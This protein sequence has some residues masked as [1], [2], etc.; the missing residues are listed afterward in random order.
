MRRVLWLLAVAAIV[1]ASTWWLA[2]LPGDVTLHV[3]G[4][5]ITSKTPV[6][7]VAAVL[8]ALLIYALLRLL[9]GLINLPRNWRRWRSGRN[10]AAGDIATTRTLV[11]L[12]AG[13]GPAARKAALRALRLL[14]ETPQT[15]L[16]A[17]EAARLMQ[18]EAEAA[19]WFRKLAGH[20]Q[21]A[22]L[23]LRGLFRQ[24]VDRQAWDEAALLLTQAEARQPGKT[25]LRDTR[26][27][28]AARQ[29]DWRA[30]T[31]L[32]EPGP[33]QAALA[34]AASEATTS[35]DEALRLAKHAW[36][37]AKALAPAAL[38]YAGCLRTAG[39]ERKA[40]DII[41]Q[42]WALAPHPALVEFIVAPGADAAARLTLFTTFVQ[43]RA[44][45]P[46]AQFALARLS[47][48]AGSPGDALYHLEAAEHGGLA[49]RRLG[50]LRADIA[51]ANHQPDAER[52][53]LR[54][55]TLAVAPPG[56]TCTACGAD[57]ATWHP[58]CPDCRAVGR[59]VWGTGHKPT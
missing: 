14:G 49:D 34:I 42:T 21:G 17:A 52:T 20:D 9:G 4:Y 48:D 54:A 40:V 5:G 12:A 56:W 35:A 15:L 41:R 24:A 31:A 46:E 38:A 7:L 16:H 53:A 50:L 45:H 26:L 39:Q 55:A 19:D 27:M 25:W 43:P 23:G 47:L 11:A 13:D 51:R 2:G 6:A 10:R 37:D 59:V 36:T 57:Q 29:G 22:F 30:A 44:D 28:V 8:A 58:S 32:A 3:A 33:A 18:R 1:V